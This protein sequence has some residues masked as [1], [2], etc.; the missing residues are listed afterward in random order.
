MTE[1]A[2]IC[3]SCGQ[4]HDEV[5]KKFRESLF[6]TARV[7]AGFKDMTPGLHG[8]LSNWIEDN[9]RSNN[10]KMLI[11]MARVYFKTSLCCIAFIVYCIINNPRVR[12]LLV[13]QSQSKV[14]DVMRALRGIL[15]SDVFAHFF[16][17]LV[18]TPDC[19]F[20]NSEIDVPRDTND[21]EPTISARG[22]GSSVVGG[23][24]DVQVLDDVIGGDDQA[25]S[26]VEMENAIRW[27]KH[28]APLFV[29][30][31]SG[32]RMVIGTRWSPSDLYQYIIDS[33]ASEVWSVG[34]RWDERAAA[35]GFPPQDGR[36][37]FPER[38]PDPVLDAMQRERDEV[39]WAYQMENLAIARGLRR[40]SP[41]FLQYYKWLVPYKALIRQGLEKPL[42]PEQAVCSLMVDPAVG[43]TAESDEFAYT[44]CGW[45]PREAE[46]AVLE[47]YSSRIT[48]VL[49]AEKIIEVYKKW[50]EHG[51]KLRVGIEQ[52]GY[53][54]ALK[55][56]VQ[57]LQRQ[58]DCHFYIEPITPR[59]WGGAVKKVRRIEAL[60]PYFAQLQVWLGREQDKLE[61]QLLGFSP[62][63]D[64][65]TGLKHD[66]LIDSLAYHTKLWRGQNYDDREDP[67][68][69]FEEKDWLGFE[70]KA[71][72]N[73]DANP[74]YSLACTT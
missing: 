2:V 25:E 54:A 31:L 16:P 41:E 10:R 71:D 32:V 28:S 22:I 5:R 64:G 6:L 13:Q 66:D 60:Q 26:E 73:Q 4:N 49:Q 70:S 47:A 53:Q 36:S 42:Y 12:I 18:P 59:S 43:E 30:Y 23:H 48:P 15:K 24:Y 17:E 39:E 45:W 38:Y 35:L 33:G 19:R 40:F 62:K 68:D 61:S 57:E 29:D 1:G 58:H 72:P 8:K 11:L 46:A 51:I 9:I 50:R 34:C 14:N 37:L 3:P 74:L 20:S 55:Y 44:V 69:S 7:L 27:F 52:G 65:S 56:S 63:S 67:N 21:P